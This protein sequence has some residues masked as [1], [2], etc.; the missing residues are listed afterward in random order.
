MDGTR[1]IDLDVPSRDP[2]S[3]KVMYDRVL[4][5]HVDASMA[6]ERERAAIL[7]HKRFIVFS[8]RSEIER[9]AAW[10]RRGS[11]PHDRAVWSSTMERHGFDQHTRH[12]LN[13]AST[14]RVRQA[15][16]MRY[17]IIREQRNAVRKRGTEYYAPGVCDH[18]VCALRANGIITN[19]AYF[20]GV[21]VTVKNDEGGN[22]SESARKCRNIRK[23]R[24]IST[25]S[26]IDRH[27]SPNDHR[28]DDLSKTRQLF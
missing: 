6:F 3:F 24:L 1:R 12:S 23:R 2:R 16:D 9:V 27:S 17:G 26:C 5:I 13:S 8:M 21:Y 20:R 19:E 15:Y 7:Y 28:M 25:F 22:R 10:M 4:K 11:D 14:T 18:T